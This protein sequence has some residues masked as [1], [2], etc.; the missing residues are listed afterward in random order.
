M[1]TEQ[2]YTC[3]KDIFDRETERHDRLID[4]GKVYLSLITVYLGI[5]AVAADKLVPLLGGSWVAIVFYIA[6]L[7][8]LVGS[9]VLVLMG[10]GIH[11]YVYPTDP[12][13]VIFGFGQKPPTNPE[14]FDDRIVELAAAFKTNHAVTE[15]RATKLKHGSYCLLGAAIFQALVL[16]SL[17]FIPSSQGV[18]PMANEKSDRPPDQGPAQKQDE[19]KLPRNEPSPGKAKKSYGERMGERFEDMAR[20]QQIIQKQQ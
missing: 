8:C 14:F 9:M 19:S 12:K 18:A 13:A 16:S 3:F 1:A 7:A 11:T 20:R 6:S 10:I 17:L 5:L 2:Q 15:K 4:R